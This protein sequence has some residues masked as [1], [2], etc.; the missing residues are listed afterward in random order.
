V[1]RLAGRTAGLA[2]GRLPLHREEHERSD[3]HQVHTRALRPRVASLLLVTLVRRVWAE[4][5]PRRSLFVVAAAT[6][7]VLLTIDVAARGAVTYVDEQVT[8]WLAGTTGEVPSLSSAG[9]IG[10][11]GGILAI[12]VLVAVQA[13]FRA[14]PLLLA[15]GNV[16]AGGLVVVVTKAVVGRTGPGES[17]LPDGYPGF[18][19]SGHTAVAALC[20]GTAAF[21]LLRWRG[22]LAG[23]VSPDT[24]GLVAGL[25]A[26]ALAGAGAVLGGHHWVADVAG[27]LLLTAVVL[28]LGFASVGVLA[29]GPDDVPMDRQRRRG[30]AG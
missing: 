3:Q 7:L 23:R 19:P 9:E 18:Y 12:V 16:G 22:L 11:S 10:L 15:A 29:P 4:L 17:T 28:P 21:V 30:P 27:S 25:V 6:L 8:E 5:G 26:G 14:W 20:V 2:A 1:S 13:T 24:G